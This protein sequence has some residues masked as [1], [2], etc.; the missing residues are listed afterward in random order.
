MPAADRVVWSPQ[1]DFFVQQPPRKAGRVTSSA[2]CV[3]DQRK[4]VWAG[5]MLSRVWLHY[6]SNG[7]V[8]AATGPREA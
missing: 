2:R 4:Q 6:S 8:S 5:R 7:H 1:H 3:S